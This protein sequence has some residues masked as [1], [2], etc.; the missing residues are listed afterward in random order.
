LAC[1][2]TSGRGVDGPSVLSLTA[3]T[4][5]A[6]MVVQVPTDSIDRGVPPGNRAGI[7]LVSDRAYEV[8]IPGDSGGQGDQGWVRMQYRFEIDRYTGV[9]TLWIGEEKHGE[10]ARTPLHCEASTGPQF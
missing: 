3:A 1:K 9:G 10:R 7:V 2:D 8:T 4:G 5:T 6:E